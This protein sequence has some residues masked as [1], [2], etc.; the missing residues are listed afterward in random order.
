MLRSILHRSNSKTNRRTQRPARPVELLESRTLLAGD[1]RFAVIGDFGN[2][3]VQEADVA[4]RVKSWNPDLIITT[5]DNNYQNGEASTIDRNIGKHYQEFIFPYKG[6]FGTGSPTGTNRFFPSL[7]NHDWNT[8]NAQPYID[9]FTLPGNEYYY[10]YRQGAVEFFSIDSDPRQPDL[11]FVNAS[12]S[13]ATSVQGEWLRNALAASDAPWKVV[14][15]H[16][17]PFSSGANHGSAGWMRWPFEQW[18][19]DAVFAGHEHNYERLNVGN[20]PYFVNGL[21]GTPNIYANFNPL[22]TSK[23]RYAADWGAQLVDADDD[24]MTLSFITRDGELIDTY[25][26][27]LS[28]VVPA[29]PGFV[30]ATRVSGTQVRVDWRDQSNNETGFQIRRSIDGVNFTTIGT[31]G[32][33]V[34]RFDDL[35]P[36]PSGSVFYR[37]HAVNDAGT[38]GP[39][40]TATATSIVPVANPS[41][42]TAASASST[43]I[44]LN[45][46]DNSTNETSFQIWRSTDNVNFSQIATVG[47]N[48]TTFTN[49]GLTTGRQ[50]FYRVR[51]TNSTSTSGF[52]NTASAIP[53][54]TT[55]GALA[56]PT[57]LTANAINSTQIQLNWQ[58]NSTAE[59]RYEIWRSSNGINFTWRAQIASNSTNFT[60]SSLSPG[61]TWY[62]RVR[63]S[64]STGN[65][66]YSNIASATTPTSNPS[67]VPAAP[68]SLN[69]SPLSSSQVRLTW[70]DNATNETSYQIWRST[71]GTNFGQHA[72]VGANIVLYDD[73]GLTAG[74]T[75]H[76]RVRAVNSTGPSGFSNTDSASPS[77]PTSGVPAGPSNLGATPIS[78]SAITLTW[79]DNSNNEGR[80]EIFRSTNGTN[81]SF[82]AQVGANRTDFTNTGLSAGTT[83]FYR[84]R[85]VNS[86]G[87]SAWSNIAS[88]TP[89][90]GQVNIPATPSGLTAT[91]ASSSQ[92]NLSWDDNSDNESRFDIFR[93]T[94]GVNFA[95]IGQ[96]GPNVTSFAN[97]GLS[98]NVTYFYRVRAANSAGNSGFSNTA[99]ATTGGSG[100]TTPAAPTSL[101]ATAVSSSQIRLNWR[102]NATNEGR[103][104]I[105]R[106]T[107]GTTFTFRAQV[108]AN[109]TTYLDSGLTAGATYFYRV[110]AV[111]SAGNSGWSNT[112]SARAT[113]PSPTAGATLSSFSTQAIDDS[114]LLDH[115]DHD[116]I[117]SP[118]TSLC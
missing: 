7:G 28:T 53:A 67:G 115:H 103:Y 59:T 21:G 76:Y 64:N 97:T 99:N 24:S 16:H 72:T 27:A 80:F 58:D 71:D 89:G 100:I 49:S 106:S 57:N 110:R 63:A 17:P 54:A 3:G 5:G 1:V 88:A 117:T 74:T 10:S 11:D 13:T 116:V 52:S 109:G 38:S 113:N 68:T 114:G 69:A 73:S 51:G 94:D 29:A 96:V 26:M 111:N 41:N 2:D 6:T 98:A 56:Q 30:T 32:P 15:M 34:E 81:F 23:V 43:S 92:I 31:V 93:S 77:A 102:D 118:A 83:Y 25:T 105:F 39:S 37:V 78:S 42:L 95:A 8:P 33:N 79:D 55:T 108:G 4:S 20:V 75:Y 48:V 45:W 22:S 87:N 47:A 84:V 19:A 104:E 50:Y 86:S 65:S 61:A 9:Y 70:Q 66:G 91:A 112:V 101:T 85:A 14:Y 60:D 18:G 107:N 40:N 62:Y 35:S 90:G 46:S 12:T 44:R 82:L 36:P